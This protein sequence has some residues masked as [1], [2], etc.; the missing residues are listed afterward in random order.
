MT[1]ICI[2]GAGAI[3]GL[4]GARLALKGETEVSLVARGPHLA[5]MKAHGLTLKQAGETHVVHPKVSDRPS[6]LG[7]QDYIILTLKAHGL[8]GVVEQLKP[9]IGPDT[10]ILF[11][12][13]G[14]PWWYFHGVG[15]PL[16]DT[17]LETVD[18]G[19][20]IWNGIGPERA[21]GA[22]VW[23]AAEVEAPGVVVH[24]YGDRMP[25]GEPTG[26]KSE[27]AARLSKLLTSAGIKSPVRPELRNEIWL[28]LWGNL[29]FNP[30]SVLTGG[31]LDALATD[32]GTRRVIGTMMEEARAVAEAL[33][34]SFAVGV[35]ERMDMAARVGAHRTS[36]LQ[37][38]EAGRPTELDALL[39]VVLEL[40]ALVRVD[41]PSLQLVYDLCKFRCQ[42]AQGP[43]LHG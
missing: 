13:N 8:G 15:G 25:L 30:V 10:A 5:A 16:A 17:R 35:E 19:G 1:K 20:L 18:P 29:S 39:G 24:N 23:Q 22:V 7:H 11:A 41:T 27:R 42:R 3:G 32:P 12:Q 40:A 4:I 6:E 9:L 37:D 36:M 33:G 34:A 21:L 31:M 26:E 43:S 28:K 14:I 38:V 2:F